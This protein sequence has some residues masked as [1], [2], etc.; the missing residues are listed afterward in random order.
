MPVST[1]DFANKLWKAANF[2]DEFGLSPKTATLLYA[3]SNIA[4][5]V[6]GL[7]DKNDELKAEN[8]KLREL[9]RDYHRFAD[10]MCA[11][12]D[13]DGCSQRD[14]GACERGVLTSRECVLGVEVE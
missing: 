2:Y 11:E 14:E 12:R 3:A 13:C 5:S 9:V 7:V 8:K 6:S 10:A 1:N 4:R